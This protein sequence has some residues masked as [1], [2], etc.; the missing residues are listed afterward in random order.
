[1]TKLIDYQCD[2]DL[3]DIKL[4]KNKEKSKV[5]GLER[6]MSGCLVIGGCQKV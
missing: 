6:K 1:M 3:E 2:G 4:K 5:T